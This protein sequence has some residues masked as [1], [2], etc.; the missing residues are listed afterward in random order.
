MQTMRTGVCMSKDKGV[1]FYD[2]QKQTIALRRRSPIILD[3]SEPGT[4]KTLAHCEDFRAH[5]NRKGG[6]GLVVC[7]LSL[8]G[9][10]WPVDMAKLDRGIDVSCAYAHNR[11]KAFEP[12]H[13]LYVTNYEG[14]K[15]LA[16][17]WV[18]M[19]KKL[20]LDWFLIDEGTAFKNPQAQRT[21]IAMRIAKD[22]ENRAI[23]SG[24]LGSKSILDYWAP[25][26]ILDRGKRLGAVHAAFR[27]SVCVPL[28]VGPSRNMVQWVPRE[29]AYEAVAALISDISIRHVLEE[30][31]DMPGTVT[32]NIVV[33]LP[34]KL[35]K[36]YSQ[37]AK[38]QAIALKDKVITAVNGGVAANKLLQIAA[39]S[40][41][42]NESLIEVLDTS[43]AELIA[44]LCEE[45]GHT[46]IA[47]N[48]H[49]QRDMIIAA[50]TKRGRTV[51][52]IDGTVPGSKRDQIVADFQDGVYD[53]ILLHPAAAAHGLTLTRATTT[54]WASPTYNYEHF[55]Q[56]NRRAYRIGQHNR[57]EVIVIT[58]E[59]TLDMHAYDVC[60]H[61]GKGMTDM[62]EAIANYS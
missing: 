12:G 53:D 57:C 36:I 58:A 18:Q 1:A 9:A 49:H 28:Q 37:M 11:A 55:D 50:L 32:H 30:C 2:H 17:N 61:H 47:F 34:P 38:D 43:R 25:M 56:L 54:I 4:G 6:A 31:H 26:V 8:V 16:T 5:R 41:Y 19:K 40:L 59:G 39:G 35:R 7:P 27:N 15:Y 22:M 20:N 10:V 14:L 45:R 62:F 24:T 42:D 44:D 51:A 21:K 13:D 3:L 23:L 60:L 52:Y 46:I 48:W 29:G 33:Q